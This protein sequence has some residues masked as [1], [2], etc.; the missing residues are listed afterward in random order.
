MPTWFDRLNLGKRW[1]SIATLAEP[2][3]TQANTGFSFLGQAP[4]STGLHDAM[5]QYKDDVDIFLWNHLKAV[6]IAG[7]VTPAFDDTN[8]L[9]TALRAMF[10]SRIGVYT[11]GA[12]FVVPNG[13][14]RVKARVWGGG[15][16]GGAATGAVAAASGGGPGGYA[17]GIFNVTPAASIVITVGVGGAGGIGGPGVAG[18][19]SSFGALASATGG[20]GAA[21]QATGAGGAPGNPGIGT[22]GTLNLAGGGGGVGIVAGSTYLGGLGG[23]V[24]GT[25]IAGLNQGGQGTAGTFPAG[26]GN[27]AAGAVS[28][29]GRGADGLVILEY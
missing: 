28:N 29:G 15:G 16:G 14:T 18:G 25:S 21:G 26:G 11:T 4:P 7:G 8:G 23:A 6:L 17:E 5:F 22:G 3:D 13:V 12:T 2:S 9:I 1:G 19:T 20:S 24:F 27:G 10:N